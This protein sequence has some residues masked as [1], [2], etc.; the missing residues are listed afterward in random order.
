MSAYL[1]PYIHTYIH[2][3]IYTYIHTYIHI[4]IID[5]TT[6]FLPFTGIK[7]PIKIKKSFQHIYIYKERERERERERKV[8]KE[9]QRLRDE[10]KFELTK[11][12]RDIL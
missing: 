10:S 4:L 7:E 12:F 9:G 5:N 11:M 1:H 3:Y 2:T 8:R 6:A